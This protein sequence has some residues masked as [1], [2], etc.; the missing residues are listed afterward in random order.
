M[1]I[2][3]AEQNEQI[4]YLRSVLAILTTSTNDLI[5]E[6][7]SSS[8][9]KATVSNGAK[10]NPDIRI[11]KTPKAEEARKRV[12]AATASL[13][14]AILTPQWR[15]GHLAHSYYISRA[16][17]MVVEWEIP[18]LLAANGP[19]T[20]DALASKTGIADPSKL[21]FVMRTLCA[22]HIFA[23]T[24][25]DVFANDEASAALATD[26]RLANS[27][28]FASFLFPTADVLPGLLK[29]PVFCASYEP[30]DSA[31]AKSIGKGMGQFEFLNA[32]PEW[33]DC[34]DFW[35]A[36][37]GEYLHGLTDVRGYPWETTLRNGAVIVDVG[38]GLGSSIQSLR[39]NFPHHKN[40]F[41]GIVQDQPGMIAHATAHWNKTDPQAL[42]SG[43]VKL[44]PHDFF[45]ENPVK[46]ADV[47]WFR[48]VIVDW[49]D[50]DLTT[51]FTH[52]RK[53]MAPGKSRLLIGE[54]IPHPTC[55][56]ALLPDAPAPLL[57]NYGAFQSMGL[58]GGF[59]LTASPNGRQ[60]TFQD[61]DRVVKAAGLKIVKVW[62]CRGLGNVIEC[63]LKEDHVIDTNG[64]H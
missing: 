26:E 4:T 8:A 9:G 46:G 19:M 23:E 44:T 40:D 47:Y 28:R 48:S 20:L 49:Q 56:D 42:T 7:S 63:R 31:F 54:Y 11:P 22:H 33:R 14:A 61:L 60:R 58:I 6:L 55:G 27:V 64:S 38:G 15:L 34:F 24:S 53:A 45:N 17:H 30:R 50:K 59:V 57:K 3:I 62:I 2:G 21:G 29:D 43:A 37:L 5:A 51:M 1:A 13:E 39:T 52:I 25:H 36:S 35:L 18:Q 10:T 12:I 32:H 16:L 41:V